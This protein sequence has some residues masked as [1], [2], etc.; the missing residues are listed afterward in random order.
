MSSAKR[1]LPPGRIEQ[2]IV[3]AHDGSLDALGRLLDTYRSYLLLIGK[4]AVGNGLGAKLSG[5]DL[6][7]ETFLKAHQEFRQFKGKTGSEL[8]AWLRKIL[9]NNAA[10]F[11]RSY[12]DTEK[13]RV[14][15]EISP[16]DVP[17][18]Q[19]RDA[20]ADSSETPSAQLASQEANEALRL[21]LSR[22]SEDH[23]LVLQLREYENC[24]Y[25]EIGL[26]MKRSADAARKLYSRALQLL[27]EQMEH[28]DDAGRDASGR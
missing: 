26:R 16:A 8:V 22:L 24:G 2:W 27:Q 20:L 6:V 14:S 28:G 21:A 5:S 23:R 13:R 19:L 18:A 25:D 10:N 17:P 15:R 4:Q 12:R 3:D 11:R 1:S 7:Q 9:L